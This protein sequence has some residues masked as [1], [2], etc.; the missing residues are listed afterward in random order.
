M[1][2]PPLSSSRAQISSQEQPGGEL[3]LHEAAHARLEPPRLSDREAAVE[4]AR[5]PE[6]VTLDLHPQHALACRHAESLGETPPAHLHDHEVFLD[7]ALQLL[8]QHEPL[9]H[10]HPGDAAPQRMLQVQLD[11]RAAQAGNPHAG[12]QQHGQER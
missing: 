6:A 8:F 2:E 4:R 5:A 11:R 7:P 1:G 12:R 9:V 10:E 3:L